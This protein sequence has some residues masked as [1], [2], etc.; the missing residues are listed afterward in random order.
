MGLVLA[1]FYSIKKWGARKDFIVLNILAK[2][3]DNFPNFFEMVC[4]RRAANF[5]INISGN[6]I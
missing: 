6:F 4:S 2:L 3:L 5:A 1:V